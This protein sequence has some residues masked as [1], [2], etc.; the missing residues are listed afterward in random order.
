MALGN[1]RQVDIAVS[2]AEAAMGQA[3]DE[4]KAK[5][6]STKRAI[7]QLGDRAGEIDRNLL[8]W[9]GTSMRRG[10]NGVNVACRHE[11]TLPRLRVR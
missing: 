7:P 6:A 9:R 4:I 10:N 2:G 3:P 5:E 11:M 1:Q 8:A